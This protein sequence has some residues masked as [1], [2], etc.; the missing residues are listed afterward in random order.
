MEIIRNLFNDKDVALIG[1]IPLLQTRRDDVRFWIH[2]C[3]GIFTVKSAYKWLMDN[4]NASSPGESVGFWN[5]M[6]QLKIPP[7]IKNF[8]WRLGSDCVPL[9]SLFLQR[10]VDIDTLCSMCGLEI[11]DWRHVFVIGC[12]ARNCWHTVLPQVL[13]LSS[14]S[15]LSQTRAVV[16]LE[17]IFR[18]LGVEDLMVFCVTLWAIW[19]ARND[20]LWNRKPVTASQILL[21]ASSFFQQWKEVQSKFGLCPEVS[22]A[23]SPSVVQWMQPS[24][25]MLKCNVDAAIFAGVGKIGTGW[26]VR[27]HEGKV[28]NA[29]RVSHDGVPDATVA[30][31]ISLRE[32]W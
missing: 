1:Q 9:K 10:H 8:I 26:V 25:G 20:K 28:L 7:K 19:F 29:C 4:F 27:D 2:D 21:K 30:E 17:E 22:V 11:E 12:L 3:K 13:Q 15:I 23:I 18:A 14:L 6:W 24:V 31:A 16:W 5:K 32:V